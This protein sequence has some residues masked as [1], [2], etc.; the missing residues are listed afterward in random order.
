MKVC[1]PHNSNSR[2]NLSVNM[3]ESSPETGRIEFDQTL[4]RSSHNSELL[5][6]DHVFGELN[7]IEI[8]DNESE[9]EIPIA[10]VDDRDSPQP[11]ILSPI[12]DENDEISESPQHH[13]LERPSVHFGDFPSKLTETLPV[14]HSEN[15]GN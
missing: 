1:H 8:N 2:N 4:L 3:A 7:D 10:T 14:F 11:T 13:E 9:V 5:P 12:I 6:D 15:G